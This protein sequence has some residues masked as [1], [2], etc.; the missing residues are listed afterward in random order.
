MVPVVSEG[1]RGFQ[2]PQRGWFQRVSDGFRGFQRVSEGFRVLM[3]IMVIMIVVIK[4]LIS[5]IRKFC[6]FLF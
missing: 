5:G 1:F 4:K 2:S 3:V 6:V